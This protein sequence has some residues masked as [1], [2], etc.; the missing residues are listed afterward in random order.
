MVQ[1]V[2]FGKDQST[3]LAMFDSTGLFFAASYFS[4]AAKCEAL[5]QPSSP[6]AC[7]VQIAFPA[8]LQHDR[9]NTPKQHKNISN[10]N[11]I[12]TFII[13]I[14][15]NTCINNAFINNTFINNI[16]NKFNKPGTRT[17]TRTRA[18]S[19]RSKTFPTRM[20]KTTTTTTST[21][22]SSSSSSFAIRITS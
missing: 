16:T 14:L 9:N 3:S 20:S 10:N 13:S 8:H 5:F 18:T 2:Y 1:G 6:E 15:S 4:L 17:I 7:L 12:N 19:A 11:I 21:A 22:S